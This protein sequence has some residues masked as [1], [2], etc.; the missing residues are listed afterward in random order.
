MS[1]LCFEIQKQ[2]LATP[3]QCA[4][5]L[6]PA[7]DSLELEV[8][9]QRPGGDQGN[10][11]QSSWDI[12][13][14]AFCAKHVRMHDRTLA[15][16]IGAGIAAA[17][18]VLAAIGFSKAGAGAYV[19]AVGV[20]TVVALVSGFVTRSVLARRGARCV[21]TGPAVS[22]GAVGP[23]A[24]ER[25]KFTFENPEFGRKVAEMNKAGTIVAS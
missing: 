25:F 16:G 15:A 6:G 17:L 4:C 2:K 24:G 7:G 20:G 13:Y 11:I 12:P 1:T 9:V 19:A 8:D 18:I 3:E 22:A 21:S 5:C 14:C 10:M 23:Y